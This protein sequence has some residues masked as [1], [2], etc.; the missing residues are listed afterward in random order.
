MLAGGRSVRMGQAKAGLEWHGSTLLRRVAGIVARGV[1]GPVVVVRSPGQDLPTLPAEIEVL[2]DPTDALLQG[3]P[4]QGIAVALAALNGRAQTA[5]VCATD[6]PFLHVAYVRRVLAA[7]SDDVEI[8]LPQVHGFRQPLAAGY[9]TALAPLAA[10]L[11]AEGRPAP[12]PLLDAARTL[13]LDETALL[14]DRALRTADPDLLSVLNLNDRGAYDTA[15]AL[16]APAVTVERFGVLAT[17]GKSGVR[18]VRAATLGA[19]ADAVGLT[20]DRYVLA[21]VNGDQTGRDP[22]TPLV[23]GDLVAFLSADAGG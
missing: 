22:E 12:K 9:A 16:P 8:V 5:F 10:R 4:L 6:L 3:G 17:G 21:A 2:D 11:V 7:F 19:A 20:L 18:H 23:T 15:R 14:A 1:D 13:S